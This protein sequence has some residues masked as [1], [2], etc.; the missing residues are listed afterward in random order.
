VVIVTCEEVNRRVA[1]I[2]KVGSRPH[3]TTSLIRS[4]DL[5]GEGITTAQEVSSTPATFDDL[6]VFHT[7][8][9][10]D[11]LARADEEDEQDVEEQEEHGLGYDCP[12]LP[13]MLKWVKVVGGASLTAADHLLKGAN[14]SINWNGG[15]H[16]AHRDHAGGFCYVN[17]VVLAIH[18]L[19]KGFKRVLYIDLDVHH[20]DGV[21]EA[22]SCT[23]RVA[24]LSLHL[25]EP[26]FFPGS[27]A[28]S[29]VGHG[30]GRGFAVNMPFKEGLTDAFFVPAFSSV[31]QPLMETFQPSAIVLQCGADSLARD[32]MGGFS[33]TPKAILA[34]VEEVRRC[35]LPLLILGGGGY[36]PANAARLWTLITA[37]VLGKKLPED[38]P[39]IDPY[40][41]HYGP[42][43]TLCLEPG[44][45]K[46]RNTKEEVSK[47]VADARTRIKNLIIP[48]TAPPAL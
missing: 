42:D 36:Q 32:P 37:A 43:F 22:F 28:A 25:H 21:E 18:S 24:T 44:S 12:V 7:R 45:R 14:V 13:D 19:Q 30:K 16:H 39:D 17:D 6:L 35:G 40:F 46:N 8:D 1:Q 5:V 29:E 4:Y 31:F 48:P 34:A 33:L 15:W 38:I 23:S 9:Y 20:G 2:E 3:L 27:G 26:G 10:L 47:L 11:F 41:S